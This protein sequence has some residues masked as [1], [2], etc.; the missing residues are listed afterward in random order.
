[1]QLLIQFTGAKERAYIRGEFNSDRISLEHQ[2]GHR[3]IVLEDQYG[4]WDMKTR[5]YDISIP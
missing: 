3:F 5:V 2:D 4:P 1:M